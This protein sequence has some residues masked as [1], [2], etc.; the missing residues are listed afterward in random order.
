MITISKQMHIYVIL[1]LDY[2]RTFHSY[3]KRFL[4]SSDKL[5]CIDFFFFSVHFKYPCNENTIY[6]ALTFLVL[7]NITF[8]FYDI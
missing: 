8:G 4:L 1:Q 7:L 5:I 2:F 6:I 3:L